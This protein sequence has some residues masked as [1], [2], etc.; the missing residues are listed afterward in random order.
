M[1]NA[2]NW[3]E[4]PA[5]DFGRAEKFYSTILAT[6]LIPMQDMEGYQMS[7][8]PAE[9][10]VGGG[11]IQ[12]EGYVPSAEGTVVYLNAGD[13]LNIVLN[14]VEAAGGKVLMPK[15]SIG[16]NGFMAYFLD[17]EGNKVGLHSMS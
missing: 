8:F 7:M 11:V 9:G 16:E 13:D 10:G 3:F 4:I 5:S 6:E 2:L 1:T 15:T 14:R 17:S 12:G